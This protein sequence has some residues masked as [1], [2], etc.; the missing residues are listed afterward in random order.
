MYCIHV[1]EGLRSIEKSWI[2]SL[3][4]DSGFRLV[5]GR[6]YFSGSYKEAIDIL[7]KLIRV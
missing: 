5:Q 3:M 4:K 7:G 6:E 1:T 2:Q